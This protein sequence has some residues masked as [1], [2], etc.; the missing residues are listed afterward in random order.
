LTGHCDAAKKR[1]R[2]KKIYLIL[3]LIISLMT[4]N[5]VALGE[6]G[7]PEMQMSYSVTVCQ[8]GCDFDSIKNAL[9]NTDQS[10][11]EI[12]I[13]TPILTE[14]DIQISKKVVIR[15]GL[16]EK[17]I[18]K[19]DIE[20]QAG[21]ERIFLITDTG[22]AL[23]KNLIITQGFA[24]SFHRAGGGINNHGV[25]I[26]DNCEI[27]ENKAYQG[28]GIWNKGELT[29]YNSRIVNN[30]TI[31]P[32]AKEIY[33]ALGCRGAGGGIKNEKPGKLVLQNSIVS[34]NEANTS[35]GGVFIAC[36]SEARLIDTRIHDNKANETG[37][38]VHNRGVLTLEQ[39][40]IT[41]NY[42]R[43]Q[44]N[45]LHSY[46]VMNVTNSNILGNKGKND[47]TLGTGK[48]FLGKGTIELNQNSELGLGNC[49]IQ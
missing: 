36:E 37:G 23:F 38:G 13:N 34:N 15:S 16:P 42:S 6:N 20:K 19:G 3:S 27:T 30:K 18:I 44:G 1:K 31:R 2:M 24:K 22:V 25:L 10:D 14:S 48:G 12:I 32:T 17:V 49:Q 21:R 11:I 26:V 9:R 35:G 41:D 29:I 28:G 39:V 45:G 4:I 5:S 8:N 46:G 7:Y 33:E 43:I 47:C 40:I